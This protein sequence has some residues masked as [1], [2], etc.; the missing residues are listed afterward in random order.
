[1][2]SWHQPA[3][4]ALNGTVGAQS[5]TAT[6]SSLFMA[7]A[8]VPFNLT[9][10]A[11]DHVRQS[12]TTYVRGF[13][14]RTEIFIEDGSEVKWRR[15]IFRFKGNPYLTYN[16]TGQSD[17]PYFFDVNAAVTRFYNQLSVTAADNLQF[18]LFQGTRGTDWSNQFTAAV[19][20]ERIMLMYDKTR[21]LR[22]LVDRPHTHFFRQWVPVNKT[23]IYS[24]EETS[25]NVNPGVSSSESNQSCGDIYI[26][27]ILDKPTGSVAANNKIESTMRYYWHEK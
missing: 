15:I 1:M 18:H 4:G 22:N 6:Y 14:E 27:D 24:D 11:T 25:K 20:T 19:D 17:Q 13:A 2:P 9:P 23:L 26:Y 8:R 12:T 16:S 5:F 21:I 7:S 3:L 10:V